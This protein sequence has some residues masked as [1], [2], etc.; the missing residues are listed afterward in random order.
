MANSNLSQAKKLRMTNFI[1]NY[2]ILKMSY[3]IIVS[4]LKVKLFFVTVMIRSRA[5]FSNILH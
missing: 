2:L 5:T 3:V 4:I 1:L